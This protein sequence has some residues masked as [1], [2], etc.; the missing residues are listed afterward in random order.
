MHMG[1]RSTITVTRSVE[2]NFLYGPSSKF[3]I[4]FG[5]KLTGCM[6]QDTATLVTAAQ[7]III[8]FPLLLLIIHSLSPVAIQSFILNTC[9]LFVFLC[10]FILPFPLCL[11]QPVFLPSLS[12]SLSLPEHARIISYIS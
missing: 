4:E 8:S 5:A 11:L 2:Q 12:P 6:R 1:P 3:L 10:Y 7:A 9:F